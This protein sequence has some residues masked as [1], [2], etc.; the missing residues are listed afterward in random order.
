MS[1]GE[2]LAAAREDAGLTVARVSEI[3]CI[4]A[5]IITS[6]ENDD[7]SLCG[8][9][10]YARGHIRSIASRIGIDPEPLVE[11]YDEEHGGS[12][13]VSNPAETL[14]AKPVSMPTARRRPNLSMALVALLV[15]VV[16]YGAYA[17]FSG[18]ETAQDPQPADPGPIVRGTQSPSAPGRSSSEDASSQSSRSQQQTHRSVQKEQASGNGQDGSSTQQQQA[19]IQLKAK[20]KTWLSVRDSDGKELFRGTLQGGDSKR[21]TDDEVIR[22]VI[23]NVGGVSLTINGKK[24]GVV[25]E[26]GRVAEGV[27]VYPDRI[28][29]LS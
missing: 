17:L 21:F 13:R 23:G 19:A 11:Q 9:H 14:D 25:G 1:I 2:T 20:A 16:A 28:V 4:R 10:F 18:P 8:G 26:S 12:P 6:I 27:R 3:T 22:V 7:F 15:V 24:L 5:T 29:G